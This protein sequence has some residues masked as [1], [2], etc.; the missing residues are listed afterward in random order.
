VRAVGGQV[1]TERSWNAIGAAGVSS[2]VT[3]RPLG[4][5]TVTVAEQDGTGAQLRFEALSEPS[6]VDRASAV[7]TAGRHGGLRAGLPC[8][9]DGD[10]RRR[11]LTID[12]LGQRGHSWGAPDW[13]AIARARTVNAWIDDELAL[14]LVA[15]APAARKKANHDAEAIGAALFTSAPRTDE[16]DDGDAG[17]P[18]P[19]VALDVPEPRLSTCSTTAAISAAPLRADLRPRRPSRRGAARC[20]RD[21]DRPRRAA[22]GLRVLHLADGG[23]TSGTTPS[24]WSRA[25]SRTPSASSRSWRARGATSS[26]SFSPAPALRTRGNSRRCSESCR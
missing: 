19:L 14:S 11:P 9:R 20:V 8:D 25:C 3:E 6:W 21:V 7:G 17:P 12:C 15:I 18:A 10:D 2:T 1:V 24:D 5:W 13:D 4:E 23:A 22:P 16:T 26:P